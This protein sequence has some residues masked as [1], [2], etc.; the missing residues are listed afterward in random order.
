VRPED[1]AWVWL[2]GRILPEVE[3]AVPV[4]DRGF[5]YGDGLFETL[6]SRGGH[7]FRLERHLERLE[8]G[9]A[10]TGLTVPRGMAAAVQS[11]VDHAR[12]ADGALRVTLTRGSGAGGLR[13][14]RNAAPT[15]VISARPAPAFEVAAPLAVGLSELRVCSR[16]PLAGLKTLGYLPNVVA[17]LRTGADDA[18]MLDD[19]GRVAQASSSNVFWV[20]RDGELRTPSPACGIRRGVTREAVLELAR[21]AGL[22]A[23][24]GEW[25]VDGLR[26]AREAFVTSSLRGVA[27]IGSLDGAPIGDGTRGE[28][29]RRLAGGYRRLFERETD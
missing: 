16:S 11:L 22:S 9:A 1:A 2:D 19:E 29:T 23:E 20:S 13:P 17:L 27:P 3:A 21:E 6:R 15:L 8:R 4:S 12:L 10:L 14:A 25:T 24:E 18:L 26:E 7:V 28:I 5:V